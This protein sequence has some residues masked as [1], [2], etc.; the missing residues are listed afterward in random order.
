MTGAAL[1]TASTFVVPSLPTRLRRALGALWTLH[2]DP[3]RLDQVLVFAQAVNAVSVARAATRIHEMPE[4]EKLLRERRRIDRAHVDFDALERLPDGTLGREYARF[5]KDNEISPEPFEQLPDVGD[6]RIAFMMLRIRQ[7]HDLWH[8]LTGYTPDIRG[9]VLLQMFSYAQLGVPSALLLALFGTLRYL[10][11]SR[12]LFRDL[13]TAYRRG[14][15]TAFLPTVAW[16]DRWETP[17][18]DLRA[19]LHCLA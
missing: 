18:V 13:R 5:L 12:A 9:E 14:K 19:E 3:G 6:E 17:I 16:E 1:S 11:P 7:T 4:G 10:G 8:V 2:R 15:A